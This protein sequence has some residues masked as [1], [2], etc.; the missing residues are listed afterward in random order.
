M[1]LDGALSSSGVSVDKFAEWKDMDFPAGSPARA[2]FEY[3]CLLGCDPRLLL[4]FLNLAVFAT[5]R[6]Q[7]VY[8]L[9]GV[10]ESTLAK[11]PQRLERVSHELESVDR[12]L[13]LYIR[14]NFVENPI[15][16]DEI[17]SRWR[18]QAVV[19]H[20]TP[21]LLR[22]LAGHLRVANK[23]LR[24]IVGPRRFDTCRRS[25]LDLLEYVDNSAGSP[26]YEEV[27]KL[28]DHL[29]SAQKETLK[30]VAKLDPTQTGAKRKKGHTPPKLLTSPDA[31]KALY[32][33][34]AKYGFR[35]TRPEA[36][37]TSS[38]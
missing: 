15:R 28:L 9:N 10:S 32:H 36:S 30:G 5:Q 38:A 7:T 16:P 4:T 3:L 33:R 25:V 2:G 17:R 19:Y 20:H 6:R 8:D 31:L 1:A 26:H 27:S 23:W 14:A 22:L 35:K 37:N 24:E 18:Q 13:D 12:L 29:F 11:L 34:S 21:Q